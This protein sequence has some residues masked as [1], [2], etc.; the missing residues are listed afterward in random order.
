MRGAFLGKEGQGRWFIEG[1]LYIPAERGEGE[2]DGRGDR[3]EGDGGA[4][5]DSDES[6]GNR[7]RHAGLT[8]AAERGTSRAARSVSRLC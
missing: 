1:R 8:E 4:M 7:S 6:M 3:E 5:F 2:S